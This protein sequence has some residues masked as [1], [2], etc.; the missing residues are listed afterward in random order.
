MPQRRPMARFK[1]YGILQKVMCDY[2]SPAMWRRFSRSALEV[3]IAVPDSQDAPEQRVL[4][5]VGRGRWEER[6]DAVAALCAPST[7]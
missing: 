4:T 6:S 1:L 5:L 3:T 7:T 2:S